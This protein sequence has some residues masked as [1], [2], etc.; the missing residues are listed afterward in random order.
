MTLYLGIDVGGTD[1]KYALLDH[2]GTFLKQGKTPTP[3][4]NLDDFLNALDKLVYEVKD[5][6]SG[7][8][9]SMPGKIDRDTGF[10]YTGGALSHFIFNLPLG[11]LLEARYQLPVTIENDAK[12][13][14]QAEAWLGNLKDVQSGVVIILGTGIGGGII[15]NRE[16]WRG[17]KGSAGEISN[18]PTNYENLYGPGQFWAA[19]NGYKGL[20]HPYEKCKGLEKNTIDGK[21][22][23][24]AYHNH[25]EDAIRCFDH[26]VD[27]LVSGIITIQTVLDVE[28]YCIGGGI[29]AQDCLIEAIASKVNDYFSKLTYTPLNPPIIERCLFKNDANIIGALKTYF[30]LKKSH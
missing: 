13:A 22:F 28:K 10:M 15:L 16:I 19:L 14:A 20:T 3:T 24:E 27:T 8:A 21:T 23:F 6:I 1:I 5:E 7:I 17:F 4:T 12:C 2:R 11:E 18:L 25:D 30:D 29:S 26:F 9:M